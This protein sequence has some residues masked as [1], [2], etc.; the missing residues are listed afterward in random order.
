[1]KKLLILISIIC[2]TG[3]VDSPMNPRTKQTYTTP[4]KECPDPRLIGKWEGI[5][6]TYIFNDDNTLILLGYEK[7]FEQ[8]WKI[9]YDILKTTLLDNQYDGWQSQSFKYINTTNIQVNGSDYY[10]GENND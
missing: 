3:C 1:M 10:K 8:E 5:D 7:Q 6:L 4:I 9:E 2:I